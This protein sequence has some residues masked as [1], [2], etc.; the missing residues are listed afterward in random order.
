MI[1][2]AKLAMELI[3]PPVLAYL[4]GHQRGSLVSLRGSLRPPPA[5]S[6]VG[7]PTNPPADTED[8]CPD[9]VVSGH[10]TLNT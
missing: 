10:G 6:V 3:I 1:E 9:T 7:C 8:P 5:S 2:L 4:L